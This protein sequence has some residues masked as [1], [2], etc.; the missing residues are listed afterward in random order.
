MTPESQ[1]PPYFQK[2]IDQRFETMKIEFRSGLGDVNS[3]L[4]EIRNIL[5]GED[6]LVVQV[7]KNTRWRQNVTAKLAVIA[8]VGSFVLTLIIES[9]K[10]W[11]SRIKW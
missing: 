9:L 10:N 3:Q 2:Y 7:K 5:K 8:T 6:G 1:L 4:K 11:A